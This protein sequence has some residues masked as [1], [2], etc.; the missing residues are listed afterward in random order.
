MNIIIRNICSAATI[1]VMRNIVIHTVKCA[2]LRTAFA[3][4]KQKH[5]V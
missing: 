2:V 4:L 5:I 3:K 1:A